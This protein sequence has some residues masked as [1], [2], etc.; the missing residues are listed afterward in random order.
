MSSPKIYFGA[1][2][3]A[4]ERG[5]NSAEDIKPWLDVLMESKD[6]L[7]GIDSA[8]TYRECEEWLGEL[9]IGSQYGIPVATKLTGGAHPALVATKDN[10]IAQARESLSKIGVEQLDILFLHAPDVRLPFEE[11]LSG[12][13][14]LH[15]EG[16]F[17]HFGLANHNAEQIEEVVKICKEKGFILPTIF[18]GSYNPIARLPEDTLLP[19]LRKHNISFVAYSPMAGGFLAKTSQ[20]FRDQ[21]ETL[22][23][24]WDKDGFLGKVYHYLYNKPLPLQALDKWHEIAAT[25]GISGAEMAYRWVAHN[26]AL[27]KNDGMVVGATTIEQWKSNLAAIRKGPLSAETAAKIDALWTPELKAMGT[28]DNFL[29]IKAVRA[30]PI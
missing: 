19:V 1:G 18:Q 4:K 15:K 8:V 25:E 16:L 2:L 14:A 20:R 22:I 3:F 26:S 10:V 9:K 17:K 21:P 7:G 13:D 24:R 30:S 29:A 11:T 23:G 27:T 5:Y 6:I 12:F 28:L